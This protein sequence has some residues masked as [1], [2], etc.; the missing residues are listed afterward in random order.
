MD[1]AWIDEKADFRRLAFIL[2]GLFCW[3]LGLFPNLL[4]IG[5]LL[6]LGMRRWW[7]Y[8]QLGRLLDTGVPVSR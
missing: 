4:F 1:N 2:I 5:Y 8:R 7:Y 3:T 6:F